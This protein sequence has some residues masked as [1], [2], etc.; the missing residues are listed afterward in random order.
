MLL[1]KLTM[2]KKPQKIQFFFESSFQHN[3]CSG[4]VLSF[5]I[6]KNLVA[7]MSRVFKKKSELVGFVQVFKTR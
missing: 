3:Y 2:K 4:L 5:S 1:I 7:D 6:F